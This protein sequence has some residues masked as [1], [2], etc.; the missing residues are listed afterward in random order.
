MTYPNQSPRV[1]I[2]AC[3]VNGVTVDGHYCKNT[4]ENGQTP[5]WT[6]ERCGTVKDVGAGSKATASV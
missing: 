2:D 3:T 4:A 5:V 1:V 6:C